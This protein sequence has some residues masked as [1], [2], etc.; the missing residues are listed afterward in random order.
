ML[1]WIGTKRMDFEGGRPVWLN[2][3]FTVVIGD[4]FLICPHRHQRPPRASVIRWR[5]HLDDDDDGG[6]ELRS[7]QN[8]ISTEQA[9]AEP[10]LEM[11]EWDETAA[12]AE[13][14]EINGAG[15]RAT[16]AL[17]LPDRIS[18]EAPISPIGQDYLSSRIS[19]DTDSTCSLRVLVL[20]LSGCPCVD[21]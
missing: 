21:R 12:A 17:P 3:I 10:T 6:W 9:V 18:Y 7:P 16:W 19:S 15:H 13:H 8:N 4:S 5:S 14:K 20:S 2:L 11:H 1:N